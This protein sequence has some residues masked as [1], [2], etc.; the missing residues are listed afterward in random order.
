M[1]NGYMIVKIYF[2]DYQ[3]LFLQNDVRSC[4]DDSFELPM[5]SED[6]FFGEYGHMRC[7]PNGN[8][9]PIQCV[10]QTASE[11]LCFCIDT[12]SIEVVKNSSLVVFKD[13]ASV[14]TLFC[15]DPENMFHYYDYYRP[16]EM[17]AKEIYDLKVTIFATLTKFLMYHKQIVCIRFSF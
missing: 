7:Q 10:Q 3:C 4:I 1:T 12:K 5:Y 15:Y 11:G 17:E 8:Y 2:D 9:D 13:I 6:S 16:C 14:D